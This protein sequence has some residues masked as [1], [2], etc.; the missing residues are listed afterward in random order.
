MLMLRAPHKKTCKFPFSGVYGADRGITLIIALMILS[1]TTAV[2]FAMAAL[3]L[4]EIQSSRQL[5]NSEPAIVSAEAGAETA[6]FF[7]I[8]KLPTYT[9][10][11]PALSSQTF[12]S[13]STSFGFCNDYYDN[14][15]IFGTSSSQ[16]EVVLL[17]DPVNGTNQAAG[18]TSI[19]VTATSTTNFVNQMQLKA[20]DVNE[21]SVPSCGTNPVCS[22]FSVPG[23]G[24]ISLDP[25]KSYA[26]FLVPVTSGGVSG[27]ITGRDAGGNI[28]GLPS[29]S[30]RISSTGYKS[31]ILRKL[32][33]IL[34]R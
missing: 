11:C 10:A 34:N 15:Y 16:N 24:S 3:T 18:Y 6:M 22:T 32:E 13:G 20:Y 31:T 9:N 29:K 21:S 14:P 23:T 1:L 25:A 33:V 26:I 8:R 30:P 19:S 27:F 5:A 2:S 7:R 28:I 12:P 4:R 17:Y